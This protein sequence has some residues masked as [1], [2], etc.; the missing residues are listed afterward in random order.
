MCTVDRG[1]LSLA[2]RYLTEEVASDVTQHTQLEFEIRARR[3]RVIEI[4]EGE[5]APCAFSRS[6]CL[7]LR[8][9]T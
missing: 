1:A 8:G 4:G 9:A 6:R 7:E 3:A 5:V 2:R